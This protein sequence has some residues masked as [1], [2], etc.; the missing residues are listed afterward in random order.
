MHDREPIP[1]YLTQPGRPPRYVPD[2]MS[3]LSRLGYVVLAIALLAWGV[4]GAF[5][6]EFVIAGGRNGRVVSTLHLRGA[7]LWMMIV[8][9]VSASSALLSPVASHY[10]QRDNE[11]KYRVFKWVA[12]AM[13]GIFFLL[14]LL[15]YATHF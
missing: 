13:A 1:R 5:E 11:W 3:L 12:G 2:S 6:N 8:A 7:S 4:Y 10:D 15:W 9:L 14:S